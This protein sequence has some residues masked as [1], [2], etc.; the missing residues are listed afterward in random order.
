MTLRGTPPIHMT[1]MMP[2]AQM[3]VVPRS[4]WVRYM[5]AM[6]TMRKMST[7]TMEARNSTIP[8]R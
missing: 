6:G 1:A 3:T 7:R 8:L 4:D 5:M 2:T